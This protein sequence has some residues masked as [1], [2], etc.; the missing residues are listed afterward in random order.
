MSEHSED[1]C[2]TIPKAGGPQLGGARLGTNRQ[3]FPRIYIF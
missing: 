2:V 1:A 3:A